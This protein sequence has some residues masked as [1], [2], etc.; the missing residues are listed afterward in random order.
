MTMDEYQTA[1]EVVQE[2]LEVEDELI[3]GLVLREDLEKKI[4]VT[5]IATGV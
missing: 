2:R 5:A 3:F 4:Q 1:I